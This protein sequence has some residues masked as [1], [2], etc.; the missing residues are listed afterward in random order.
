MRVFSKYAAVYICV[1]VL[2][3]S[4]LTELANAQEPNKPDSQGKLEIEVVEIDQAEL[5]RILAPIAL[6]PDTLL[7]HIFVASTYPLE[8]V[9]AARWRNQNAD[10]SEQEALNQAENQGWDPSVHALIPFTDLLNTLSEDLDWL[11]QLG[12]AFLLNEDQ[13]LSSVQSLRKKAYAQGSLEDNEY[14]EVVEEDDAATH[15]V[16]RP[17]GV[18]VERRAAGRCTKER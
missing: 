5:D 9:Q 17:R 18:R 10:L 16:V 4:L 1:V 12:D 8:L 15:E 2:L 14:I 7:S 6:Y 13:V 11:Q 3:V